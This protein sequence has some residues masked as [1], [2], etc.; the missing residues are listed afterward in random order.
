MTQ[1]FE[2]PSDGTSVHAPLISMVQAFI[3]FPKLLVAIINGPAIGIAATVIALCDIIYA[4][5]N[6]YFYTPFTAL[7]TTI[8]YI[9]L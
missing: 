7:G 9:E 1:S 6:A 3:R 8:Q 2:F 5:E 4:S